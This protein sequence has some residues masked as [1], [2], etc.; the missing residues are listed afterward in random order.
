MKKLIL[1]LIIFGSSLAGFSQGWVRISG[2]VTDSLTG[3]PVAEHAVTIYSDSTQGLVYYNVVYTNASGYYVDEIPAMNDTTGTLYVQTNDCNGIIHQAIIYYTPANNNFT[4][5]FQI[6][7]AVIPCEAAFRYELISGVTYLFV[8][9][10]SGNILEW[11]WSFGD[12]T[13]SEEQN[14]NHVFPG[15]G[16]YNTCLT[17]LSNNCTNTYCQEIIISDTV[18]QQIY[19]QVFE[20][21]F[22]MQLGYVLIYSLNPDGAYTPLNEG[23]PVDSNGIYYFTLV[24]QGTYLIQAVP[25]DSSGY[26]PTYYGD[27]TEWQSAVNIVIG[28]PENPYNIYLAA[29][30]AGVEFE[31][32]GSLTGQINGIG[33]QRSMAENASVFLMDENRLVITYC[34]VNSNG[35]FEFPSLAFGIYYIRVELAGVSSDFMKFEVSQEIPHVD[36]VLS[37]SGNSVFGIDDAFDVV[38]FDVYPVPAREVLNIRINLDSD[39]NITLRLLT[40]TGICVYNENIPVISGA[41]ARSLR[42]DDLSAGIY[43]LELSGQ[44]RSLVVKKVIISE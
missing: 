19:G 23:C 9:L 29:L 36:V 1:S 16:T 28:E 10:S 38:S 24:P 39:Q 25:G 43:F 32:P 18:Y 33:M 17:I 35:F 27:V 22:P 13:G 31:G 15:P 7:T 3:S 2:T 30:P 41:S 6:C 11:S 26:L 14:P 12:G 5:D 42:V 8:D 34:M 4:Q 20:G 37:Y 21:N 44:N 40:L